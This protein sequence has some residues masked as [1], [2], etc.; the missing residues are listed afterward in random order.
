MISIKDVA[1]EAGVGVGTV[2]RVLNESSSVAP[3]TRQLVLEV[4]RRLHYIPNASGRILKT[5]KMG[6]I[7]VSVP[8]ISQLVYSVIVFQIGKA[9][10]QN[11][12]LLVTSSSKGSRK[13]ELSFLKMLRQNK[14]DGIIMISDHNFGNAVEGLPIVS[15]DSK[16]GKDIPIVSSDNYQGGALA[17]KHLANRGCK[18]LA[19]LGPK[20]SIVSKV[21]Q[22]WK[23]FCETASQYGIHCEYFLY[24]YSHGDETKIAERFLEEHPGFDGILTAS[25]Y[26]AYSLLRLFPSRGIRVPEDVQIIGF[27]GVIL[28]D[29]CMVREL[30]TIE[31]NFPVI[32]KHMTNLLLARLHEPEKV[33]TPNREIPVRL[34]YGDT[35][36]TNSQEISS[37]CD[38]SK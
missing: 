35:T 8:D 6:I 20:L 12:Y 19:Y 36:K 29:W 37:G 28:P 2:S 24:R 33:E 30:T 5:Q 4:I 9:L 17:A 18:N 1:R 11:D 21:D 7:G 26:L 23:G 13:T 25:D 3:E 27:D 15:L 31:Q 10:R 34:R 14:L 38:I 32:G 22:R 16:I